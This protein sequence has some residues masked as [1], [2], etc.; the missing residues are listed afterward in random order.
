[1]S[2]EKYNAWTHERLSEEEIL[3]RRYTI[4]YYAFG[5]PHPFRAPDEIR[6]RMAHT[7]A[8]YHGKMGRALAY[9]ERRKREWLRKLK[10]EEKYL[11]ENG[12]MSEPYEH[13][14]YAGDNDT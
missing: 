7:A 6:R 1:M 4:K 11:R 9:A 13:K 3:Y 12:W 8:A 14:E 5:G 2:E 10:A